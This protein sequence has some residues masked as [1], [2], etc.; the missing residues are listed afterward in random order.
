[1]YRTTAKQKLRIALLALALILVLAFLWLWVTEGKYE[2]VGELYQSWS[3]WDYRPF[4]VSSVCSTDGGVENLTIGLTDNVF[5]DWGERRILA[6]VRDDE[7]VSFIRQKY[8][9][10]KLERIMRRIT[11][12]TGNIGV[13][14]VSID[15]ENN[16][17]EVTILESYKDTAATQE[18]VSWWSWRYGDAFAV[19]YTD[20]R[21]RLD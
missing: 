8:S 3:R 10:K 12:N 17:V 13:T 14:E 5:G 1:M 2:T 21:I 15:Q 6:Q 9:Q 7:S 18:K 19:N 4:Y 20:S 16:R 11:W